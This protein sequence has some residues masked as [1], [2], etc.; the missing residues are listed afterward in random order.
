MLGLLTA[1]GFIAPEM[2]DGDTQKIGQHFQFGKAR[3]F[4]TKFPIAY[5]IFS[6]VER[7]RYFCLS[8]TICQSRIPHEH[9]NNTCPQG[10]DFNVVAFNRRRSSLL[11][12]LLEAR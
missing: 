11:L 12:F 8:N 2:A 1:D 5:L 3:R 6:D 4:P 9:T 10:V 7:F